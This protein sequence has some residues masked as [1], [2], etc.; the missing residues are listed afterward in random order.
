MFPL[1]SLWEPLCS[2]AP[3]GRYSGESKKT[4][5]R[6]W[7]SGL[8]RFNLFLCGNHWGRPSFTE[9]LGQDG[10]K[11]NI[12]HWRARGWLVGRLWWSLSAWWQFYREGEGAA[13]S[14]QM[15]PMCAFLPQTP[16]LI[17]LYNFPDQDEH[18]ACCLLASLQLQVLLR[19]TELCICRDINKPG[20]VITFVSNGAQSV[21]NEGSL[22]YP[23]LVTV[24][25]TFQYPLSWGSVPSE[26][27][28]QG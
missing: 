17:L 24:N 2:L 28:W 25:L 22:L 4:S 13:E 6:R 21:T 12:A 7:L 19:W 8:A 16:A 10:D 9:L 1:P 18:W 5:L 3:M 15:M 27:Q 20:S 26:K 14:R 23:Y 11:W